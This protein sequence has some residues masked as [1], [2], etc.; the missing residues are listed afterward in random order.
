MY[1]CTVPITFDTLVDYKSATNGFIGRCLI[2]Y[3]RE[4][5]PEYK[6]DFKP[7]AMPDPLKM[8]LIQLF[9]GGEFSIGKKPWRIQ[10]NSARIE[11]P[12]EPNAIKMLKDT[13]KW[14]WSAAQ[15]QKG[16]SGLE[17]LMLGAYEL[18]A[19]VSL[20]LAVGEGLRTAE[21]VRWAFALVKND[22]EQKI[23]LVVSNDRAKDAPA[24][25]LKARVVG[26]VSGDDGETL[27]V[28]ANR[29]RG[30]KKEDVEKALNDL[31]TSGHVRKEE[32]V[33]PKTKKVVARF[34][35]T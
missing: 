4:T 5:V 23:A 24:T 12:S 8:T 14:L 10:N 16:K 34:F 33:H 27:G 11:V 25:A 31:V 19:K 26:L 2:F 21:H 13:H 29:C 18:V 32:T 35:K 17:S 6:E 28:V 9:S 20:I 3:E 22:I 1:G 30:V 15:D 7:R